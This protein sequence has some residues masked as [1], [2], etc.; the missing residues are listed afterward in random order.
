MTCSADQV[1][2]VA[3]SQ[4]GGYYPGASPY[5]Q[6]YAEYTGQTN[7]GFATA[8]Y[9]A[10]FVSWCAAQVDGLD[11]I[12]LH[13]STQS[14]AAWFR[15]ASRWVSG[16]GDIRRGDIVYFD[17]NGGSSIHHVG[18]VESVSANGT[19]NTIEGNTSGTAGG[20]QV[21]GRAVCRKTR[22]GYVVGYGRPAY[23]EVG[24]GQRRR[25]MMIIK[26]A[27][28]GEVWITDGVVK[29]YISTLEELGEL[30]L[31]TG[32]SGPLTVGQF[33]LDRIP[34]ASSV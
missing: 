29:R 19:F 24:T 20:S 2:G 3:A 4:I 31:V 11:V 34:V 8:A 32:Q 30:C 13:A 27:D 28:R 9:C 15:S 7:Q 6:W 23:S 10:M 5:G 18:I 17:F 14:G 22:S 1:I 26:G 12:P 16:R 25:T 21:N 33:G